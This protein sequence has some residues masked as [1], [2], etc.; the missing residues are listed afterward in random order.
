MNTRTWILIAVLSLWTSSLAAQIKFQPKEK[1]GQESEKKE[2]PRESDVQVTIALDMQLVLLNIRDKASNSNLYLYPGFSDLK[3]KPTIGAM[4]PLN[5]FSEH[6]GYRFLSESYNT[7]V[8]KVDLSGS[9][10]KYGKIDMRYT[11]FAPAVLF[12]DRMRVNVLGLG[13][14]MGLLNVEGFYRA[15]I[16]G[17][18]TAYIANA[19][20]PV[21]DQAR[22][23]RDFI[24]ASGALAGQNSNPAV[25]YFVLRMNEGNNLSLLG[26]YLIAR[27]L[28]VPAFD[29][30]TY[31]LPTS[32]KPDALQYVALRQSPGGRSVRF[33]A[34]A[35][36][37]FI[38]WEVRWGYGLYGI[39][40]GGPVIAHQRVQYDFRQT[41]RMY[42]KIKIFDSEWLPKRD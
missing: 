20:Q 34:W 41:F 29:L 19:T 4:G 18:D 15:P 24:L 9:G 30:N 6:M 1:P 38:F 22:A 3:F 33:S 42:Y 36:A 37:M 13:A 27:N 17:E 2:E 12:A 28:A 5:M 39:N 32:A 14:G 11:Y 40:V 21:A 26:Q 25:Q 7:T 35:P 8:Y 16:R 23:R 10:N 31:V